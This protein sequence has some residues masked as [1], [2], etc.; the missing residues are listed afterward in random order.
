MELNYQMQER[1]ENIDPVQKKR[2][3]T[4]LFISL[5]L[6]AVYFLIWELLPH[7]NFYDSVIVIGLAFLAL[8]PAFLTNALMPLVSNIPGIKRIPIDG[9]RMHKDGQ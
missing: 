4:F 7:T 8:V 3:I 2:V 1:T 5:L 6:L 9:G